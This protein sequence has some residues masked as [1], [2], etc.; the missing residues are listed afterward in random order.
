MS[1]RP[2]GGEQAPLIHTLALPA[3]TWN[4][5]VAELVARVQVHS[6]GSTDPEL[7]AAA[8]TARFVRSQH[9]MAVLSEL[10][11]A[12]AEDDAHLRAL[13]PCSACERTGLRETVGMVCLA[14]GWD[15]SRG[16]KPPR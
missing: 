8:R 14:C 10:E 13:E 7:T 5:L 16:E 11:T 12:A 6:A 2:I 1:T 3:A 4:A 15:Y 9:L